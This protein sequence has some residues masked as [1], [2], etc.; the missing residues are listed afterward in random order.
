[1]RLLTTKHKRM[2][3]GQSDRTY[4]LAAILALAEDAIGDRAK[5]QLWLKQPNQA[6]GSVT[7][8]HALATEIGSRRVAGAGAN[9]LWRRQLGG[10]ASI[11]ATP[12]YRGQPVRWGGFLSV[13]RPVVECWTTSFQ[14]ESV[15]RDGRRPVCARAASRTFEDWKKLQ[16]QNATDSSPMSMDLMWIWPMM[17]AGDLLVISSLRRSW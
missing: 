5:A 9:R 12:F 11:T 14:D 7:P 8:L 17:K 10:V 13:W 1:M 3:A 4:R 15:R 2:A 16:R 6:L